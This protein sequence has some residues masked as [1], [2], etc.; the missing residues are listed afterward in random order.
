MTLHY[1]RTSQREQ[2][3]TLRNNP[4][5]AERRLWWRLRGSQLGV[6]F[7]RQYGVDAFVVDFYAPRCKLAIEVDGDSHFS[8]HGLAYD[9]ER[10]NC[11]AK[12]GIEVIR[13]TNKEI[14]EQIEAVV[15]A[16]VAAV[17][18]RQPPLAP[19]W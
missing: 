6:K 9:C 3:R 12:F 5:E 16:I 8:A 15:A 18:R 4:T 7:R 1:N 11:L 10:T 19:P 17:R 13:F 14:F 2:R